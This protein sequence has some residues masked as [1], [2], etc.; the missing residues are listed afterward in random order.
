M[1]HNH[2]STIGLTVLAS[3]A[4]SLSTGVWA[5]SDPRF[6]GQYCGTHTE[7]VTV[8]VRFLGYE[9][10]SRSVSAD[11]EIRANVNYSEPRVGRGLLAGTGT[12]GATRVPS[13]FNEF[14]RQ[15]E[16][17]AITFAGGVI[18]RGVARGSGVAERRGTGMGQATL[19]ADGEGLYA[20]ILDRHIFV[21]KANCGNAAPTA[22]VLQ[23][24]P[25]VYPYGAPMRFQA[26]ASDSEDAF[27]VPERMVWTSNKDGLLG[28]G[29]VLAR[30]R[31]GILSAGRHI[32]TFTA[33]DSG[34]RAAT[35]SAEVIIGNNLPN[36]V[37][38]A[39]AAGGAFYAGLPITLRG[40]A[41]DREN[42]D[43]TASA[44]RWFA[45]G[46][47][48]GAGNVASV[49]L[50]AGGHSIR[51]TATDRDGGSASSTRTITVRARPS[52]NSSPSITV[53][54]PHTGQG[55]GSARTDCVV[56]VAVAEDLEGGPLTITW[57]DESALGPPR[58]LGTGA[59]VVACGLPVGTHDTWHTI[60]ATVRD[61]GGLTATD[62]VRIYV[63]PG[64]L[65]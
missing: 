40:Y 65:I 59:R 20:D 5:E 1:K 12:V 8:T 38:E 57:Q 4:L 52:G 51:L 16:S 58:S 2:G 14:I 18:A 54:A 45:N 7:R 63:I 10:W 6:F 9:V 26:V 17:V 28:T 39:P 43:L 32:I 48:V 29:A 3:L 27:I 46:T 13:E 33:T 25:G 11:F 64:G 61:S 31:L 23:P 49:T 24:T 62:S 47:P 34:G 41:T 15:G 19:A 53:L 44:L 56:L 22:R 21:S 42:G 50:P 30:P 36:A 55:V 37:V 35:A 60:R